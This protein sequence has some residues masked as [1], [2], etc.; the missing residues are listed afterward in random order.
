MDLYVLKSEK[1]E[2]CV[3]EKKRK[4]LEERERERERRERERERESERET[5]WLWRRKKFMGLIMQMKNK[6][7]LDR[8]LKK[9]APKTAD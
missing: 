7:P 2:V 5:T 9:L 4:E 1:K 6:H 8:L 3:C